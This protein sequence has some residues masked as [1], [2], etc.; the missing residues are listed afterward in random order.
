MK[1]I[2]IVDDHT[3]FRQAL[4]AVLYDSLPPDSLSCDDV[5][6]AEEAKAKLAKKQYD[7]IVLDI[8]MPGTS[9]IEL[10]PELKLLYPETPVLMLSMYPEEQFALQ[11]MRLGASGYLTK[12]D[13]ADELLAA[14]EA[15]SHG[16]KYVGSSLS[17][18]LIDQLVHQGRIEEPLHLKLSR[19]ELEIF[20][21]LVD[22]QSLKSI[23]DDL[24]LSIKTVST[25][26]TRL[27][28]KMGFKNN[29]AL[30]SYG[31]KHPIV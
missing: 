12:K 4:Q 28:A 26:K 18:L 16:S 23:A 13:A 24:G 30:I 15:I 22:G 14:M 29:A 3:M 20:K 1:K 21:R 10:L 11:A 2:L 31:L 27:N 19:R 25:Y 6:S 17:A 9:G 7:L 8:A 5:A